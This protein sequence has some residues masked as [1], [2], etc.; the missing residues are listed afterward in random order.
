VTSSVART[1][2]TLSATRHLSAARYAG[3]HS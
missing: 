1:V 3:R 2:N